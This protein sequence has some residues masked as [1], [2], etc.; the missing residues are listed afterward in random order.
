MVSKKTKKVYS[1]ERI[2][3][4]LEDNDY[5]LQ[6]GDTKRIIIETT[7]ILLV[8]LLNKLEKHGD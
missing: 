5:Y 7:D 6:Y 2:V 4:T 3:V 1:N 8:E